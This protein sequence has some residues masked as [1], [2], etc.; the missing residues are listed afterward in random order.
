MKCWL[1][2][3][4]W[5]GHV[6]K[7]RIAFSYGCVMV[8]LPEPLSEEVR[9][10][11]ASIPSAYLVKG[12]ED[13]P[14][15]LSNDVHITVKYGLLEDDLEKVAGVIAGTEPIVVRLGRA[16]IFH[17][18]SQAVLKLGVESPGLKALHHKLAGSLRNVNTYRDYRPHVTVAYMVKKEDDPY[19]YRTFFNDSFE[20]R[21]FTVG[22][23]LLSRSNGQKFEISFGGDVKSIESERIDRIA[24]V[25]SDSALRISQRR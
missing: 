8:R 23:I 24:S 25:V 10:Y 3:L 11:G 20:G 22:Q 13:A 9:S 14:S 17:N 1:R 19:Y 21:E 12:N 6:L 15:G 16:S 5:E 7:R 2:S 18:E 4:V